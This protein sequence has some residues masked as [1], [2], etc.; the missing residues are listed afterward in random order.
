MMSI[1]VALMSLCCLRGPSISLA[2]IF[3]T[4]SRR[5][6][7]L[8]LP[9]QLPMHILLITL[10]TSLTTRFPTLASTTSLATFVIANSVDLEVRDNW[11][12]VVSFSDD[13]CN[14]DQSTFEVTG[15]AIHFTNKRSI[16]VLQKSDCTIKTFSGSNCGGSHFNLPDGDLDCHS[17]LHASETSLIL[18]RSSTSSSAPLRPPSTFA[19][20]LYGQSFWL[21]LR[22]TNYDPSTS[23]TTI[24]EEE[25]ETGGTNG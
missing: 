17:V 8:S 24:P 25:D 14:S 7:L 18:Y 15:S 23:L 12:K 6:W 11:A 4:I 16:K 13:L 19:A 1:L 10:V 21:A 20:D 5:H 22:V 3:M 9:T 2:G